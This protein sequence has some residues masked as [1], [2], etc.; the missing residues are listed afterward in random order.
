[1][2]AFVNIDM[3]LAL[4]PFQTLEI[5]KEVEVLAGTKEECADLKRWKGRLGTVRLGSRKKRPGDIVPS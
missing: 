4:N 3:N 1:L 5:K 2:E